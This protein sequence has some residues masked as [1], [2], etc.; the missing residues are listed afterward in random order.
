[1]RVSTG[2]ASC[3]RARTCGRPGGPRLGTARVRRSLA[4]A[5]RW[6]RAPRCAKVLGALVLGG[7]CCVEAREVATEWAAR[8]NQHELCGESSSS[9]TAR[10][11]SRAFGRVNMDAVA[12]CA[13]RGRRPRPPRVA[14]PCGGLEKDSRRHGR[15]YFG[16]SRLSMEQILCLTRASVRRTACTSSVGLRHRAQWGRGF[17]LGSDRLRPS[18]NTPQASPCRNERPPVDCRN[19]LAACR[20]SASASRGG[21]SGLLSSLAKWR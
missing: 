1:V 17:A 9:P 10:R 15:R 2:A 5:L 11:R 21:S 4:P 3:R 18:Q 16:A 7:P 12:G 8:P 19:R 13:C 6:V 20:E 14:I